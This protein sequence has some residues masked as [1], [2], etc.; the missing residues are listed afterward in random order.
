MR[1]AVVNDSPFAREALRWV[2][3]LRPEHSIAWTACNGAEAV[4]ICQR[5][6]PD[7]ILMDLMM[8][9]MDGVEATKRIMAKC[10]CAIVIVTVSVNNHV[11][12]VFR[13]MSA[14][15]VDA[16]DT[17][18]LGSAANS[19]QGTG[20]LLAKIDTMSRLIGEPK[21]I[22]HPKPPEMHHTS[23]APLVVIGSSAGGPAALAAV[24]GK[25]PLDFPAPI[26][27]VQHVDEDFAP[28]LAS[29]LAEQCS[30]PVLAAKNGDRPT[31]GQA[32]I[33]VKNDHLVF[34]D[35][36]KLG[37]SATP[38]DGFYRPSVDVFFDSVVD[39]WDGDAIGVILTGMGRD[40]ARGLKRMRE[41]GCHTIAQDEASSAV[42]GMPKA[43]A[44]INAAVEI[45]PLHEIAGVL[46]RR[47]R[48]RTNSS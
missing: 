16:V 41:A 13:A 43:A 20:P 21:K 15:A 2:L 12:K 48:R 9:V 32:L 45:L 35:C 10:P 46:Q 14:G 40:G 22:H 38:G 19:K 25:L 3:Q 7:L 5:D 24:L 6:T 39:C 1:I 30:I 26:V 4:E 31:P 28:F 42:Y 47:C 29:W 37:Y 27:I 36:Q 44:Q 17:P 23:D 33:A 8:P 11:D 34:T 18:A